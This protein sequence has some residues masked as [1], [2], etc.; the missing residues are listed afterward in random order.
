MGKKS[1]L[2]GIRAR[3]SNRIEFDFRFA[4]IRYRPM[5]NRIPNEANLRRAHQQLKDM[6][7]RIERG[8]FNF[9]DE[10]PDYRFRTALPNGN[11]VEPSIKP[12]TCN[13]VVDRFIAYCELRVSKDDMA[14]STLETYEEV[15]ERVVRPEIGRDL[16]ERVIYSRLAA[17][18][19]AKTKDVKKKTYNNIV[20]V[21][22]TYFKFGYKDHP[23]KFNPALALPGFRMTAKDRPRVHPFAIQEAELIIAASRRK[24]GE[25]YG[26]YQEFL[27]F[28]A[29][30]QSEIFALEVD[31]C[32][33][34]I[35]KISVTKAV[36]NGQPKNR[37][38]TN[39]DRG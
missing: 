19:A 17:V 21:V 30:R 29:L 26:N 11:N 31:D 3:G 6:K 34:V 16:F 25:W 12:E 33:L 7:K 27:F 8:E 18:V 15:L 20:S 35:G 36:V 5:I 23:G 28:T 13:E 14:P 38:K 22:R 37:T 24:H 32:D 9:A 1:E 10:F 2:S 39:Q 4:G